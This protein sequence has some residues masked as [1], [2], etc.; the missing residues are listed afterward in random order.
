MSA[1]AKRP[2]DERLYLYSDR[3]PLVWTL[4]GWPTTQTVTV[5]AYVKWYR[6]YI[7]HAVESRTATEMVTEVGFE[8]LNDYCESESPYLDHAPNPTVVQRWARAHGL[9]IDPLAFELM[10]GRWEQEYHERYGEEEDPCPHC[11]RR[12]SACKCVVGGPR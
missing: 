2:D 6:L 9:H 7:V 5:E 3:H 11:G 4:E 12:G 1:G 10:I 8:V